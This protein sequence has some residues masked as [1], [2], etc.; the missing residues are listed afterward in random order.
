MHGP[1]R[2]I[3]NSV[4]R[5]DNGESLDALDAHRRT[6]PEVP[7]IQVTAE[8]FP[9][10]KH[11]ADGRG[12][13]HFY[14]ETFFLERGDVHQKKEIAPAGYLAV[15]MRHDKPADFWNVT[16]PEGWT[17]TS[18]R[19]AGLAKWLTDVE[20]GAGHLAARVIV[21]RLWQHHFGH[22]L[23]ATPNDFGFQGERPTHPRLLDWLAVDLVQN[24]WSLKHVHRQIL[25]SNTYR[26]S[27]AVQSESAQ[28]DPENVLYWRFPPHRL[29][30]EVIRDSMLAVAGLLDTT[31][32]GP[33]TLDP[34][35]TRRS[36]YF[37]IKRSQLIPSMMLFD[38]P[39]HLVSI[40]QRS[41]T[42]IAP[43]ALMLMNNEQSR[44]CAAG[45]AKRC[46]DSDP[47]AAI[48]R[49]YELTLN[50][51]PEASERTQGAAFLRQQ[52]ES[53]KTGGQENPQELALTDYCQILLSLNE[54]VYVD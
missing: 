24:G 22:G 39:E 8:G 29:D 40:G 10:T 42:I 47:E 41:N 20:N 30:G 45:L 11:H 15:L 3:S 25:N 36:V 26:Q 48:V 12:F 44:A 43:Q 54:F 4:L 16:V 14:P 7:K 32:Y 6:Q 46:S 31:M 5:R 19:R 1:K 21:N 38:W 53:Y 35:S 50:R 9:P 17:R 37:F 2:R 34:N 52:K 18:F 33:G 49:C 13:P 28:I 27:S 51:P 23:V